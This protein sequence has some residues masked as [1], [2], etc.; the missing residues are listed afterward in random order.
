MQPKPQGMRS[1]LVWLPITLLNDDC[2]TFLPPL[3]SA[4]S[5]K[6]AHSVVV[7]LLSIRRRSSRRGGSRFSRDRLARWPPFCS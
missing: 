1:H 2:I 7:M 6:F 3:C 4:D 5:F